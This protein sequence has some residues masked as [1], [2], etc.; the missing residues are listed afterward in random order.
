M[1]SSA[2]EGS[3]HGLYPRWIRSPFIWGFDGL[4]HDPAAPALDEQ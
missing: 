4:R 3:L 2:R 1:A